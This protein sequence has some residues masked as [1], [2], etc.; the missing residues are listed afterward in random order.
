MNSPEIFARPSGEIL[1]AK[2]RLNQMSQFRLSGNKSIM[3]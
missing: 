3:G 1:T 2:V